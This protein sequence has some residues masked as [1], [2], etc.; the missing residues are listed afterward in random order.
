[1]SLCAKEKP[2]ENIATAEKTGSQ[3]K[4]L[5]IKDGNRKKSMKYDNIGNK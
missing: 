1:M 5:D 4:E 3:K 2:W